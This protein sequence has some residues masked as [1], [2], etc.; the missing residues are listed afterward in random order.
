MAFAVKAPALPFRVKVGDKV[1]LTAENVND[2]ATITS[3]TV[4]K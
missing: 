1:K 2:I 4:Q 3:L